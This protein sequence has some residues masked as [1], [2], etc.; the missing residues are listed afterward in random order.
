MDYINN[1]FLCLKNIHNKCTSGKAY[2][3]DILD[4]ILTCFGFLFEIGSMFKMKDLENKFII[5][6]EKNG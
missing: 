1:L 2:N 4:K 5:D 3:S 6:F